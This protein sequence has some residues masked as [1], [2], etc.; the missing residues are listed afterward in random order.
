MCV[1]WCLL[2]YVSVFGVHW[3]FWCALVFVSVCWYLSNVVHVN[4]LV[5]VNNML[6]N[7]SIKTGPLRHSQDTDPEEGLE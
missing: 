5:Y 3:C 7:Y 4:M 6:V 1:R 2:V